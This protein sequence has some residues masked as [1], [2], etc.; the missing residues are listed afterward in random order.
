MSRRGKYVA[1]QLLHREPVR[2]GVPSELALI[3]ALTS[4]AKSGSGAVGVAEEPLVS[5]M[6]TLPGRS[7]NTQVPRCR[8]GPP[9][10]SR[11]MLGRVPFSGTAFHLPCYGRT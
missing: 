6:T 4:S 10:E 9:G 11:G 2:D 8:S 7:V 3:G 5:R 1:P